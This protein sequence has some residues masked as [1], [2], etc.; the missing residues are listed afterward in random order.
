MSDRKVTVVIP[1]LQKNT[2]ILNKLISTLEQDNAVDE[3]L[4]IDNSC[5][6]FLNTSKKLEVVKPECNLYV[7]PS[8]NLGVERAKNEIVALLND[9]I[10]IPDNFFFFLFIRFL[11]LFCIVFII[12]L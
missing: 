12:V 10:I 2:I 6:G 11:L 8:W 7:N 9:D 3:I 1:T 4:L 5:Q